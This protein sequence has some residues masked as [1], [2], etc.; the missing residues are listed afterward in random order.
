MAI[1]DDSRDLEGVRLKFL[2]GEPLECAVRSVVLSSWQRCQHRGILADRVSIPYFMDVDRDEAF[3]HTAR[4]ALEQLQS[5]F[6]GMDIVIA[7]CNSRAQVLE[8]WVGVPSLSRQLESLRLDPGF[9][10][11]EGAV[12]T[13]GIGTA[14]A[15][16][17]PAFIRGSEHFADVNRYFACAAVPVRDPLSGRIRGVINVSSLRDLGDPKMLS[18]ARDT[19]ATVERLLLD[20]VEDHEKSLLRLF[21]Q[22]QRATGRTSAPASFSAGDLIGTAG[23]PL[24]PADL[25]VLRHKAAELISAGRVAIVD[26]HLP[27]GRRAALWSRTMEGGLGPPGMIVEALRGDGALQPLEPAGRPRTDASPGPPT[28]PN[29]SS[30]RIASPSRPHPEENVAVDR[31]LV[32][33]GEPGIGRL[34]VRARQ[35]LELLCKA[36]ECVGTTLDVTRTAQELADVAVP[37]FADY[38]AVDLA[39]SV[40]TGDEPVSPCQDMRR[41]ALG[42]IR[43][44]SHLYPAGSGIQFDRATPQRLCLTSGQSVLEAALETAH[45]WKAHDPARAERIREAGI[46]SLI[47]VPLRARGVVLGVVSFYRADLPGAFEEDDLSL[48][49]ELASRAAVCVDNARRYTRE[50]S[51]A[52]ALQRS[53][54]PH[55]LPEQNAV[56]VACDYLP[57]QSAVGGDWFDVIPLSG[58]RVALVVG[59]VV[60]HGLQA[61]A[62]MGRLRTAVRNFSDLDLPAEDVLA[63]LDDLVVRLDLDPETEAAD[64]AEIVGASCLYAVYDPTSRHCTLARAG[65][66]APAVVFP[67]GAVDYL[68]VPA[69][70]PLGLGGLPFETLDIQLPEGSQLI[71]YTDG[72]IEHR[73]RD[74]GT[75]LDRMRRLLRTTHGP[76]G[77]TCRALVDALVPAQRSDDVALL[78]ARTRSLDDRHIARWELPDDPAAVSHLRQEVARQ[79][80]AWQLG[81]LAFTT[82]L[83]VSELATNAIRYA[84]Q[85]SELRLIFDRALICEVSDCSSTSPRLRRA[86]TTDEGGRGLFLVAQLAQR[87]GTRYTVSGKVIWVEESLP[88]TTL[89]AR[90][91]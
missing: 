41:V 9:G 28:S 20:E 34:A 10:W 46:H 38:A 35:R 50:H 1:W 76:P 3:A 26:V 54:L 51:T 12:G 45:G 24:R 44:G 27:N 63:R 90:P 82:E 13:N 65:H 14:L 85:P 33:V 37:A 69:G 67:D 83:I 88:A 39:A 32:A 18:M 60:G 30:V 22:A 66:P 47:V 40:L 68:E 53:L 49:E 4:P 36:A 79:L 43:P 57:A 74:I 21:L 31:W 87:W 11:L 8:R 91:Q 62:T 77:E 58:A 16:R 84:A 89:P 61:S 19:A 7:L 64:P 48:A 81:E 55:T 56:E 6:S 52:L 73:N 71:L 29:G 5:R 86:A 15:D 70:P 2:S 75:G 42:A 80:S 72:L 59:D 78:V 23:E 25:E 17:R